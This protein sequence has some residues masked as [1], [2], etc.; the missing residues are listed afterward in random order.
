MRDLRVL[1]LDS[2]RTWRG[3]QQQTAWLME[4][5]A[6][7]G[8]TQDLVAPAENPLHRVAD[9]LGIFSRTIEAG[10]LP[11]YV[12]WR[13][14][15]ALSE[16]FNP[17]IIHAHA[18]RAHGFAVRG[19]AGRVPV[20]STRRVD[21]AIKRNWWSR[22]KYLAAGQDYIAISNA[23]GRILCAAGIA[24]NRIHLVPSG[25][26]LSR[27]R[28]GDRGKLRPRWLPT[29]SG[30]LIGFV[31]ALVEHKAPWL[32]VEALPAVLD[33]LPDA[34][35]V[36]IGEGPLREKLQ[37]MAHTRG[38]AD[39]VLITGWRDDVPDALAALDLFVMPSQEEGLC[40]SLLDAQAAG[41]PSVITAAG[42]MVD[43]VEDG[44]NG[45]VVPIGAAAALSRAII[46]LWQGAED[47]AAFAA[48]GRARVEARFTREAMVRGNVEVY[49][50][51]LS[52]EK[53]R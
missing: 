43:I 49:E 53:L 10:P 20:L 38:I 36:F 51:I 7:A 47:R 48:A 13:K 11:G 50:R 26:D 17:T 24:E 37:E 16:E 25:V 8:I 52:R 28:S 27:A 45:L 1:H 19:F 46:R 18:A 42:G 2:E 5:L 21:F 14:L 33:A 22:R 4:G 35:V 30:P 31:G 40:T 23:I 12:S 15:R 34:R 41:I 29:G 44:V 3:G 39:R 9:E 32:L 6:H